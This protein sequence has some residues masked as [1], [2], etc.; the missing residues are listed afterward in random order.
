MEENRANKMEIMPMPRLVMNVSFPLMVSL[1]VQ[2]VYNIVDSIFVARISE[3]A[4]ASTSLAYP[5]QMLMVAVSVG[6]GVGVNSLISRRMGAKKYDEVSQVATNGLLLAGLSTLFFMLFGILFASGFVRVYTD[7]SDLISYGT[8][9]LRICTVF[10]AGIFVATTA[11]RMLQATGK[12][13]LSMVAQLTGCVVNL[14]L[15]PIL[16]FGLLGFPE[17]GVAGAAI[18]TVLGQWAAA[19][20]AIVLNKTKN[21]EI[22]FSFS[23]F[24]PSKK[25][26]LEI[27]KVGIPSIMVQAIGSVMVL[28]VNWI[29]V[30]YSSMAVA[31]FGVY[32]KLQNF[33][34]MPVSGL[35][36]GL[37]PII[38]YNYGAKNGKRIMEGFRVAIISAIAVMIC[39]TV[40]FVMF[41]EA[42]LSLYNA[43]EE[44]LAFGAPALRIIS[45]IFIPTAVYLVI[46][47]MFTAM[48]N[49]FV[50]MFNVML[51]QLMALPMIYFIA[52]NFGIQNVWY[53][54]WISYTCAALFAI[55]KFVRIYRTVIKPMININTS[56]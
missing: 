4:L 55:T 45:F 19:I 36:Q 3:D 7:N 46:G 15:D 17:M 24:H 51:S 31:F 29:L 25:I 21:K 44:M 35:S 27:Y 41:P 12:T 38:G 5:V 14:I 54:F 11:E 10:S 18:A 32:Y 48:G 20:F 30:N 23:G 39:G 52:D 42:L 43:G 9:Y 6:T 16:I 49:G 2:S 37:I 28:G 26:I 34:F 1:L 22:H 56:L 47:Y 8:A 33:L 40:V 53:A 50:N 13:H